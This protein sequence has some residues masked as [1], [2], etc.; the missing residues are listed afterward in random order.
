VRYVDIPKFLGKKYPPNW[1]S[2][3]KLAGLL[4]KVATVGKYL[5]AKLAYGAKGIIV[6]EIILVLVAEST[7]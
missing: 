7:V 2:V 1:A 3:K 6:D 4:G 5:L